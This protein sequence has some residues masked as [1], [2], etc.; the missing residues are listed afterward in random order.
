MFDRLSSQRP[1]VA[2][3]LAATVLVAG[4]AARN[5]RIAELKDRPDRYED[6]RI[7][8]VG[9]VTKS[10]GIPL[11]PFQLYNVDDGSGEISVVSQ[12]G[13][14]PTS[15]SRVEVTG[16]LSEVAVLGGRSIGLHMREENRKV[17]N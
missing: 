7:R 2:V 6:R 4:C 1:L 9:V 13:R 16:R 10:F 8:I 14:T 3:L 5:V 11:V 15:G 17:R 12:S